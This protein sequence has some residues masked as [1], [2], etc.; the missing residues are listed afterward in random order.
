MAATPLGSAW[1]GNKS[2]RFSFR[3]ASRSLGRTVSG[4]GKLQEAAGGAG[5]FQLACLEYL[6]GPCWICETQASVVVVVWATAGALFQVA[7]G[8]DPLIFL[9]WAAFLL[10]LW[11]AVPLGAR[12]FGGLVPAPGGS[13][14]RPGR[15]PAG[16]GAGLSLPHL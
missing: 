12:A 10:P 14:R 5:V 8:G 2:S 1:R 15:V 6:G 7:L 4:T 11:R 13:V 9:F 16:L 3:A